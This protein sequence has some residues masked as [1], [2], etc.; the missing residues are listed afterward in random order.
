MARKIKVESIDDGT[1]KMMYVDHPV[2]KEKHKTTFDIQNKVDSDSDIV[3]E[4]FYLLDKGGAPL[5]GFCE[6]MDADV[7]VFPVAKSAKE[8][9]TPATDVAPG[10]YSYT[11]R[12]DDFPTLDPVIIIQPQMMALQNT[13]TDGAPEAPASYGISALVVAVVTG[14][15]IGWLASKVFAK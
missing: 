10:Y 5:P 3:V 2:F 1:V 12:N 4:F 7:T 9:C 13:A 14:F 6:E 15:V 11:V 8:P